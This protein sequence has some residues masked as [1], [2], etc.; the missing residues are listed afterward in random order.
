MMKTEPPFDNPLSGDGLGAFFNYFS[1]EIIEPEYYS[2]KKEVED[3][4]G[5]DITV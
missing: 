4:A 1:V 3:I 5:N 2:W